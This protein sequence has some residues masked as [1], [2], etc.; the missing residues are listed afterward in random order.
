M[1][2]ITVHSSL[3]CGICR[4]RL[5]E[6]KKTCHKKSLFILGSATNY[7]ENIKILIHQFKYKYWTRLKNVFEL[8]LKIYI[9]NLQPEKTLK[10]FLNN[11]LI[12][13]VPL[14]KDREKERGF[15][16]AEILGGIISRILS[17]PIENRI[18]ARIKATQ[19]Q[20][21]LKNW[22]QRKENLRGSFEIKNSPDGQAE[23]IKGA[24]IILVDDVYT[25]GATINEAAKTL[26]NA[27]AKQIIA[28][29]IAKTK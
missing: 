4:A 19:T 8:I 27:G 24:N 1:S 18:I 28:F 25:S 20:A 17:I 22:E 15:N 13:P 16:Q 2:K 10:K 9:E 26:R 29:V 5:P 21:K 12:V 11:C 3:F 14:H 7:D 23:K 6:N